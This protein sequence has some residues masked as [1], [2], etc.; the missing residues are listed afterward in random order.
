MIGS[1]TS[2][3]KSRR[4]GVAVGAVWVSVAVDIGSLRLV[5]VRLGMF[6]LEAGA[7]QRLTA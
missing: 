7:I 3:R 4:T 6:I 5:K 2:W 1:V